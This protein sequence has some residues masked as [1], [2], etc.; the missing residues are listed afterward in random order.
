MKDVTMEIFGRLAL[1]LLCVVSFRFSWWLP[2]V[3]APMFHQVYD[4]L[5]CRRAR[6]FNPILKLLADIFTYFVWFGYIVF[7]VYVFGQNIGHWYGWC[8]GIITGFVVA[9]I[10]G[11]LFPMR[12]HLEREDEKFSSHPY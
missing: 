3:I 9:Q 4:T 12:W 6:I 2:V 5:F 1:I 10:L 7:A 11:L 8:I